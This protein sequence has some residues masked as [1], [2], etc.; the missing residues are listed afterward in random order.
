MNRRAL[1]VAVAISY[2]ALSIFCFIASDSFPGT[3]YLVL[4]GPPLW[5]GWELGAL[6][7]YA[8]FTWGVVALA[9]KAVRRP[10]SRAAAIVLAVFTWLFAGLLS[11][12][13]GY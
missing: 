9:V 8:L 2:V 4:L 1:I 6:V 5:L 13:N 11:I 12:G 10:E 3:M 7:P